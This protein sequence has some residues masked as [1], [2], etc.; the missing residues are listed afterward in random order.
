MISCTKWQNEPK[1]E[2]KEK[3][4]EIRVAHEKY[5]E[6]FGKRMLFLVLK[7]TNVNNNE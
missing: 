3:I 1:N 5:E 7:Y 6:K 2:N 4:P